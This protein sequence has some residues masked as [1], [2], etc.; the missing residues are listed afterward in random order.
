MALKD[1]INVLAVFAAE[2]V[3]ECPLDQQVKIYQAIGE[4]IPDQQAR[5]NAKELARAISHAAA[6]QLDFRFKLTHDGQ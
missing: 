4:A 3:A 6:L 2:K 1:A 5:A